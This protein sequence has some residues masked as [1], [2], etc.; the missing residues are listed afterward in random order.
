MT[1]LV[2]ASSPRLFCTHTRERSL[3]GG[4]RLHAPNSL[5]KGRVPSQVPGRLWHHYQDGR[6]GGQGTG[7]GHDPVAEQTAALPCPP[8]P[9]DYT[10]V[11]GKAPIRKQKNS[12]T[13]ACV[14]TPH[15]QANFDDHG[16][17]KR[18]S[19]PVCRARI[20]SRRRGNSQR[21]PT[22]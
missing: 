12:S 9:T 15:T 4:S 10:W 22:W 2:P 13:F 6:Q 3:Q 16:D 21:R 18:H 5:P 14:H 8:D 20:R 1:P 19:H 17:Q 7:S 11:P